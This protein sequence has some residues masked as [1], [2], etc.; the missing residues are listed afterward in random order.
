M[1]I[2][3]IV[4]PDAAHVAASRLAAARMV[5]NGTD[6]PS[7]QR[8]I[9]SCWRYHAGTQ[10]ATIFTRESGYHSGGWWKNPDYERCFHL[11]L[12]FLAFEKGEP[13]SLPFNTVLARKWVEAFFG[14]DAHLTWHEGPYTDIGKAEGVHHYRLFCDLSWQPFKPRG[15]VYSKDWTPAGWQSF[16]D[17][18]GQS[19][20]PSLNGEDR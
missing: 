18:H 7:G 16:S 6:S 9:N 2:L 10:C 5:W 3:R 15:E 4:A 1:N 13:Y 14:D 20:A 11:S 8:Y 17:L 19:P 12:R